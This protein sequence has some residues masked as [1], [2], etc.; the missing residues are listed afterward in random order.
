MTALITGAAG[1]MGSHLAE[2]LARE[3]TGLIATF[4]EPTIDVSTVDPTIELAPLD[5]CDRKAVFDLIAMRRPA[6]IYH[7]AA[8]SLPTVSWLDPWRTVRINIEGTINIFEAILEARKTDPSYDPMTV[9]ACSSAEYGASLT[10][11]RIPIT[12]DAPLMPLHPYGVSKVGQD[13]L[14]Y[15][16][17]VN[18]RLR[19]IRARIFN[20][21]GP[22][23]RNDVVSDFGRGVVR[24]MNEGVPV[25]HGNLETRRAIIDVRD[26]IEALIALARKGRGD[27][28]DAAE[29]LLD[30][31]ETR[32]SH[33]AGGFT[34][35]EIADLR[36]RRQNPHMH[37]FEASLA[38]SEGSGRP[39]FTALAL[40]L[41][42]LAAGRMI[43]PASA[44]LLEYFNDDLAP[45]AGIEGRI[46]EPG[47]CF[48]WAWLFERM[49][50]GGWVQGAGVSDRLTAF[51][52]GC[53]IDAG[54]GI[55]VNEVLTDGTIH[56]A[57]ARLWP[58][59]ERIK[60]AVA[61]FRRT[62]DAA[63]LPRR[64]P[65]RG[66]WSAITMSRCPACGATSCVRTIAGSK[67]RRRAARSIISAVPTPKWL[68]QVRFYRTNRK[69]LTI[70]IDLAPPNFLA[71]D[72]NV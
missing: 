16:Y 49:A 69:R 21:T 45:A 46:A 51:A 28:F 55:A 68:G 50:A 66:D 62:G 9:I 3:G 35:G 64:L 67:S 33:P 1:M 36:L 10:P 11:E 6:E 43:D 5:V 53:G 15:Q 63:K 30:C 29:D 14:G 59:T 42:E 60:A 54:R 22:R 57:K 31:I 48:E 7:L 4:F 70:L 13:L 38:L 40:T 47:H 34:E 18:Y 25:L 37:M 8:Q 39:R 72:R 65:Q 26:M 61:R 41:A 58:Q 44:A 24:A 23:K 71:G 27:C 17:F 20:C 52:R 12:E 32:W 19:C 56:D 2:R